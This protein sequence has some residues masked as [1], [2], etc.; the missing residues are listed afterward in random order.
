MARSLNGRSNPQ[1]SAPT[2]RVILL[3]AS[4]VTLGIA[5]VLETCRSLWGG[6]LDILGA[7]GHGRSYGLRKSVLFRELPGITE[8]GLW[9][10]LDRRPAAPTAALL[11]DVGNDLL[12][13][14]PVPEIL[15]WVECCLDR[16]RQV[17]AR[18]II[19][20]LPVC[21]LEKV[22]P[23]KF[24]LMRTVLYPG[25]RLQYATMVERAH[26]LDQ[27]LRRLGAERGVLLADTRPEW[28]GF[29]PIHIRR[30]H[31]SRAWR[32]ILGRWSKD[33]PPPGLPPIPLRRWV[34]LYLLAPERRWLFGREQRRAQ[35][36]AVW[37][38]GTALS[39]Y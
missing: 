38:D 18:T 17:G 31:W 6:P 35:P 23:A 15:V 2:H 13:D 24:L 10:A 22:S 20:G 9:E 21:N 36:A 4:N 32:E 30:Q 33:G 7:Y 29:D 5:T 19:T 26:D 25:C 28:Y 11:T 27:G 12:Y 16:V 1:P 39:V 3:G 34:E 8:C 14:V 37:A